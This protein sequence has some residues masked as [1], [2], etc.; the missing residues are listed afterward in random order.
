MLIGTTGF[1]TGGN[2][3]N[4]VFIGTTN[5]P[6]II[7]PSKSAKTGNVSTTENAKIAES[8][9]AIPD[10]SAATSPSSAPV[11]TPNAV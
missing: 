4:D 7:D 1:T 8:S 11:P 6:D 10:K 3:E 5:V 2:L 9:A